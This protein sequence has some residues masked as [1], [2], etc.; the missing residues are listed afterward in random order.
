MAKSKDVKR[1]YKLLAECKDPPVRR[2]IL[3]GAPEKLVKTIC[4]GFLNVERED[5]AVNKREKQAFKKHRKAI[6]KLTSRSY[7]L[8]QKSTFVKQKGGTFHFIPILLAPTL[9]TLGS[10]LFGGN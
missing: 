4:N 9:T 10:T 2:A 7:S 6:S 8:R 5:I 3:N 1:A